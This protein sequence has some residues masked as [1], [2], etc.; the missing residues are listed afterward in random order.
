M[1]P[2]LHLPDIN[3][4]RFSSEQT[5]LCESRPNGQASRRSVCSS[6]PHEISDFAGAPME[7]TP[8]CESRPYGQASRRSICSSSPHEISDFAGA[9]K[10]GLE[11]RQGSCGFLFCQ[12]KFLTQVRLHRFHQHFPGACF[13]TGGSRMFIRTPA[14]FAHPAKYDR[15]PHESLLY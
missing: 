5:P 9:L 2:R 7:Q 15:F 14:F 1:N 13:K 11:N 10:E 3:V 4:R 8:L 12:R 6:S